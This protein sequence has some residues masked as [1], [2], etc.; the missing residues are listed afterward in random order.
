MLWYAM[1][2]AD[3]GASQAGDLIGEQ[4]RRLDMAADEEFRMSKRGA[5]LKTDVDDLTAQKMSTFAQLLALRKQHQT[6]L[7]QMMQARRHKPAAPAQLAARLSSRIP[8]AC[9]CPS[10]ASRRRWSRR[11]P[12]SRAT[13]PRRT[14]CTR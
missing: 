11:S 2:Q 7:E 4:K 9:C 1:P 13:A 3:I 5:E 10:H 12:H 8:S 14:V 6:T